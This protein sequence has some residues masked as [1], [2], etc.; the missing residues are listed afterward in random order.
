MNIERGGTYGITEDYQSDIVADMIDELGESKAYRLGEVMRKK[1][2]QVTGREGDGY[3]IKIGRY[4]FC[5]L[6]DAEYFTPL[7]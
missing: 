2:V 6:V 5:G 1:G 3:V 4:V 7:K